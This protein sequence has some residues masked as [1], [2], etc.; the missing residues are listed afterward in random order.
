MWSK[1]GYAYLDQQSPEARR[2][3]V[4]PSAE[5]RAER[6]RFTLAG[7]VRAHHALGESKPAADALGRLEFVWS[8]A[9]PGL[10]WLTR[11]ARDRREGRA[12]RSLARPSSAATA[13][14]RSTQFGPAIWA[15]F[16]APA[17][18]V[19]DPDRQAADARSVPRQERDPRRSTSAP[20]ARTAS[21][22][23]R[24]SPSGPTNGR[25]STPS[26]SPSARTSRS[27]T[28]SRRSCRR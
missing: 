10:R 13:R 3:C 11:R 20:A 24:I 4:H 23:S 19:T 12:D 28:P 27:R 14:P 16:A 18:D 21:S 25:D 1:L 6:S 2:R 8:D 22:R 7:L 5:G 26:S 15:P 9:E 17:L